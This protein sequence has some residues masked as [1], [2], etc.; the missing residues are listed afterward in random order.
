M[1]A[2]MRIQQS[3]RQ[4]WAMLALAGRLD[5]AT[6]PAV[7]RAICKQLAEQPRAIL[8]DLGHWR[9][10]TR[11]APRRSPPSASLP[12]MGRARPRFCAAPGRRWPTSFRGGRQPAW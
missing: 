3:S 9:R 7:Q 1:K 11:C 2:A 10:S 12:W 8:C 4:G 6:A 5:L